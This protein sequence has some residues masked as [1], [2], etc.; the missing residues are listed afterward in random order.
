MRITHLNNAFLKV[1]AGGSRLICDPWVGRANEGGWHSFPEFTP[2]AL[3]AFVADADAVYISHIHADHFDPAFLTQSGLI[4]K[5]FIIKAFANRILFN[6]LK[7]LGVETVHELEAFTPVPFKGMT[8]AIVPQMTSNSGGYEDEIDFDLDTSIIIHGDGQTLFNQVDN[9]LSLENYA[10][11]KAFI[12]QHFGA[13]TAACLMTGAASGYPQAFLNVDRVA[14]QRAVIDRSLEKLSKILDILQ[15]DFYIPSGGTYIIPGRY[16][17]LS[18]FIA[19]PTPEQLSAI[20]KARARF[21]EIEGGRT[22]DLDTGQVGLSLAPI[23][24]DREAA[25][26]RHASDPYPHDGF[27]DASLSEEEVERLFQQAYA[28]YSRKMAA[29]GVA[30]ALNIR[31]AIHDRLA[32]DDDGAILSPI[33][34]HFALA[35]HGGETCGELVIH[36]DRKLFIKGLTRAAS[37]NQL[38]SLAVFERTPNVFLPTAEFSINYL[39]A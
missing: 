13:L 4:A 19:Q 16:G 14:E 9:P 27:E 36:L 10:Q 6:R 1:D 39:V 23:E 3:H 11:I 8:L 22:L 15:P 2:D 32:F 34:D 21:H 25:V 38:L 18:R 29:D 24:T 33:R 5:P 7:R 37:W 17:H 12:T 26:R 35:D 31:F 20:A 28:N 30:I